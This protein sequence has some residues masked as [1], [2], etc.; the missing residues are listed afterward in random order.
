MRTAIVLFARSPE[1]EA[2]AKGMRA[3]APLLQKPVL[4]S[5]VDVVRERRQLFVLAQGEPDERD[6]V[7]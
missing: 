6:D 5:P 7:G 3:A 1:R 2:A 4:K